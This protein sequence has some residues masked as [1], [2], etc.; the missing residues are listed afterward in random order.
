MPDLPEN[1]QNY[2][3]SGNVWI[4]KTFVIVFCT[5]IVSY[6]AKRLI[7]KLMDKAHETHNLW[8]DLE[9]HINGFFE[10]VKLEDLVPKDT[11]AKQSQQTT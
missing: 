8:D 6:I 4:I 1:I 9:N 2:L 5:L 10:K 7:D 11:M 3:A